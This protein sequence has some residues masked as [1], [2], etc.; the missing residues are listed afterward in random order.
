MPLLKADREVADPWRPL[1]DGEAVPA[2]GRIIVPL[3]RLEADPSTF[4][5]FEGALGVRLEP[6]ERVEAL[7]PWLPRLL[8]VAVHFP[9]F[10]DGRGYSTGRILRERYRFKGELR[11]VG[12][13][14]VD[15]RPFLHQCGF[16][17]FEVA[18]GRALSGWRRAAV[19]MSLTYQA[20]YAEDRGALAV[21]HARRQQRAIAAE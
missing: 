5:R 2:E 13:V 3:A 10:G 14:L 19:A 20:D 16:D 11:A 17:A 1:V 12:D 15:Q 6:K 8:L 21:W 7:E 9:A 18:E 4:H